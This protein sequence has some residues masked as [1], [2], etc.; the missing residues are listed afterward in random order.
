M[1]YFIVLCLIVNVAWASEPNL[2]F[3]INKVE[4][5]DMN[6]GD[7]CVLSTPI[8]NRCFRLD[9]HEDDIAPYWSYTGEPDI[10]TVI[11]TKHA[12][13]IYSGIKI[14]THRISS[15]EFDFTVTDVN[16]CLTYF[17]SM[18]GC[19]DDGFYFNEIILPAIK[20][21]VGFGGFCFVSFFD[22]PAPRGFPQWPLPPNMKDLTILCN[23]WLCE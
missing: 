4:G 14:I 9:Y 21:D 15:E 22:P 17:R 7:W 20:T 13:F 11:K 10:V 18:S 12:T 8:Y 3:Y 5:V 1:R 6:V 16:C 19:D 2:M 23:L